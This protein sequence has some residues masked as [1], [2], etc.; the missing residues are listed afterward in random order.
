MILVWLGVTILTFF[1]ANVVPADPVAMRLGP[2]ASAESVAKL[3][4]E[5]GLDR[6]LP[7]QYLRYLGGLLRGNLGTSIWSG[8][9]ITADLG[10]YLPATLELA[11]AAL[12]LSV[13]VGIPSG[14]WA[15]TRPDGWV[16]R[17]VQSFSAGGLALPLFWFGMVLQ[18]VFSRQLDW[19]P[20][21]G[22]ASLVYGPPQ[23]LTGLYVL[24]SLLTLDWFRLGDSLQHLVLPALALSLPAAGAVARMMRAS[25]REV[26]VQEYT[27]AARARGIPQKR[28]LWRH[29]ASNALLPVVTLLGNAFNALLAGT[30]VV[31]VVFDWPG[32]GWYA[33]KVIRALDYGSIVSVTL[34]VAV[35][36]TTVNLVVDLLYQRLDPRIRLT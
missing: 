28:L 4:S 19:L 22:R 26:L 12:L 32:L 24:D 23:H 34:V 27:V 16:D 30:F 35:L 18:L 29:V 6:P 11:L 8:R 13:V 2:K 17:L 31:E 9:P 1:L 10:D 21:N 33:T 14:L 36:C 20:L 3:R 5:L 7:E 25:T 15:A